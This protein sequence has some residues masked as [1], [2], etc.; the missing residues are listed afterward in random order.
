MMT[1]VSAAIVTLYKGGQLM[2]YAK[3][4]NG[5]LIPQRKIDEAM[6][7]IASLKDGFVIVDVSDDEVLLKGSKVEAIRLFM[8]KHNAS[9][10]EAK[11][12]IEFLRGEK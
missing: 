2:K 7:L 8:T 10:V 9:L 12:A 5:N 6:E 11:A 4:N 3:L 1:G